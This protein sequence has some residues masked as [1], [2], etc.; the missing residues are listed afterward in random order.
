MEDKTRAVP[1]RSLERGT[2]GAADNARSQLCGWACFRVSVTFT[3]D[4]TSFGNISII[5]LCV[6]AMC[7]TCCGLF[8]NASFDKSNEVLKKLCRCDVAA[9]QNWE[10]S[11]NGKST[12][13]LLCNIDSRTQCIGPRRPS[14]RAE[15]SI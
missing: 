8:V 2:S 14:S 3:M 6:I 7:A 12:K 15:V 11:K 4:T 10:N 5:M 13:N 1:V 9:N